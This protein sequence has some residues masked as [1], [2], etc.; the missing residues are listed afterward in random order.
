MIWV[1]YAQEGHHGC[2]QKQRIQSWYDDGVGGKLTVHWKSICRTFKLQQLS[3][4]LKNL[5]I[6][7]KI[8]DMAYRFPEFF[9]KAIFN[10]ECK[11][12]CNAW[13]FLFSADQWDGLRVEAWG[14]V[15]FCTKNGCWHRHYL[16]QRKERMQLDLKLFVSFM[17]LSRQPP[18]PS[19][20]VHWLL[21]LLHQKWVLT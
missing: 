12:P 11:I 2:W 5:Y 3:T 8:N 16:W 20:F 19:P 13:Y 14:E 21:G 9:R 17:P 6:K 1:R 4:S 7:R 18:H 15:V 10:S